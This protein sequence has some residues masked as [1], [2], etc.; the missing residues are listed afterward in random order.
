LDD[1]DYKLDYNVNVHN[2]DVG[3]DQLLLLQHHLP[4]HG[5]LLYKLHAIHGEHR[6]RPDNLNYNTNDIDH[7][8][9][10][11]GHS[12]HFDSVHHGPVRPVAVRLRYSTRIHEPGA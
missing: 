7:A 8:D 10:D 11:D 3:R 6:L 2:Y 9:S 1:D 4:N 12:L 5:Y